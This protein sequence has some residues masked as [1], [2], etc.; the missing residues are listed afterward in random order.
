MKGE[1]E[2]YVRPPGQPDYVITAAELMAMDITEIPMLYDGLIMA[3]GNWSIVGASDTGKSM[4]LRYL[5]MC[6]VGGL[7]FLG[8]PFRGEHKSVI[9]VCTEDDAESISVILKKQNKSLKLSEEALSGIRFIFDAADLHKKLD[10]E[11]TRSPADLIIID[12]FGDIFGS[13][14]LNQNNQVRASINS[15]DVIAKRHQCSI[16]FL[17]HTGKRT[18][19][20]TPSKNNSIGSQGFEAKM[21]L[22]AELRVDA[23]DGDLRHLC[24]VKGNYLPKE[25]KNAS[26][27]LKMDENLTFTDTGERTPFEELAIK[28]EATGGDSKRQK[29]SP[30]NT[31]DETHVGFLQ[32]IYKP[33]GTTFSFTAIREQIMRR[34]DV[35]DQKAREYVSFYVDRKWIID[36]STRKGCKEFHRNEIA[37]T[38]QLF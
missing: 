3:V 15:Y 26:Y 7:D 28:K 9:I 21:R 19:E 11:L 22:V 20:Q 8:R 36:K 6:I 25:A 18:E 4:I 31:D 37:I 23:V 24:I 30:Q 2:I 13:G 35:G 17:H 27:V 29:K 16:C 38:G 10:E 34:F 1:A 33:E 12:A 32:G 14:D 5:A